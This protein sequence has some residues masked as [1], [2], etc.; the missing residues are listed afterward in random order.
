MA[1]RDRLRRTTEKPTPDESPADGPLTDNTPGRPGKKG[2]AT[3]K[4][5]AARGPVAPAPTTRKEALARQREQGRSTRGEARAALRGQA[6]PSKLPANARGPERAY[7]RDLV[8]ARFVFFGPLFLTSILV[9]FVALGAPRAVAIQ[10]GA[11]QL[12]LVVVAL[13]AGARIFVV[14]R[15]AVVRRFGTDLG[16]G[17]TALGFYAVQRALLP[18]RFRQPPPRRRRGDPVEEA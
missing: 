11:L 4:R 8:D 1:L 14:V 18:R 12:A 2:R 9:Y 6:D 15:R 17:P 5:A 13:A 10:V 7:V 3:P 16:V